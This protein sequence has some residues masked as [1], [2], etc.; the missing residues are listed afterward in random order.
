MAP[1]THRLW[2]SALAAGLLALVL[3]ACGYEYRGAVLDPPK[4]LDDFTLEAADG[5]AFT[6]SDY[7][8]QVVL[9]YF[10][11]TY[12]PDVCPATMFQIA[13]AVDALGDDASDVQVVMVSVDP[14]RDTA[15]QLGRYV[16]NFDR[17]FVGARTDDLALLDGVLAQ[18]GAF[19]EIDDTGGGDYLVSHTPAV[20][21]ID[22][23]GGLRLIFTY[24]ATGEDM[25]A[26]L[27]HLL[28]G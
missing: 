7:R 14:A 3:A 9:V 10:G 2:K 28:R 17:S 16:A 24:G 22:R 8:G 1:S 25:A 18:F 20:F 21:V 6:L 19:Y 12:C 26:D 13:R 15:D 4:P 11:Y 23:E 27:R 5:G